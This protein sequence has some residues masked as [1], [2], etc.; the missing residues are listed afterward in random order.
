[1]GASAERVLIVLVFNEREEIEV[2]GMRVLLNGGGIENVSWLRSDSNSE[3][4]GE[5]EGV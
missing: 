4:E 3:L 1:M 5:C 2:D